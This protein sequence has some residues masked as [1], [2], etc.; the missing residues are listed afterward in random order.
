MKTAGKILKKLTYP[1]RGLI[2]GKSSN[3]ENLAIAYF[4]MGRSNNSKNRVLNFKKN[5]IYTKPFKNEIN[6]PSLVIYDPIIKFKHFIIISNGNHTETI[7]KGLKSNLSFSESLKTRNF[8]NDP[9]IFTPRIAALVD[10]KKNKY[11]LAIVKSSTKPCSTERFFFEFSNIIGGQGHL[12]HTYYG[13]KN[14]ETRS[15]NKTPKLVAI[16]NNINFFMNDIWAAL[17]PE[18]RISLFVEFLNFKTKSSIRK[19]INIK[20]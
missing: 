3:G 18:Y 16:P 6:N 10:L 14:H 20:K 19:I 13:R 11:E 2:L 5:G 12:I 7:L 4:L 1:G 9:P 17:N 8:E 15:F